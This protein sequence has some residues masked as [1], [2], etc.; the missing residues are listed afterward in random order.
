MAAGTIFKGC[1]GWGHK[2]WSLLLEVKSMK[3]FARKAKSLTLALLC[4]S[5]KEL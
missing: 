5:Q 4:P 1:D 2:V 3:V